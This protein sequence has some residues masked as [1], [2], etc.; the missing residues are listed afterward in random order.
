MAIQEQNIKLLAS[1][2][3]NDVPE[4]GGAATGTQI[5]DGA[6]NQIFTDISELDR[7]YGRVNL[8][9]LFVA[10]QTPD[11]DGYFGA[12]VIVSDPPDDARVTCCLFSTEAGFDHRSDAVSRVESYLVAGPKWGGYLY[13]NHVAGQRALALIQRVDSILPTVGQTLT[14]TKNEGL[15]T[16]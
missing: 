15:S 5:T 13:E 16:Q 7:T 14:L 3:M 8:R 9:K 10:V 12:H 1:Q 11:T 6:S 2:I 4:G